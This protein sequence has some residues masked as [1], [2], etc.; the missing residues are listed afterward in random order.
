[1]FPAEPNPAW[2][3]V[4]TKGDWTQFLFWTKVEVLI[5]VGYIGSPILFNFVRA[6]KRTTFEI[7]NPATGESA[8]ADALEAN[9]LTIGIFCSFVAPLLTTSSPGYQVAL[10][11]CNLLV[12]P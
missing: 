12:L 1:M 8:D 10:G 7:E 3:E 6:F 11:C 5:F 4:G 9:M 2:T